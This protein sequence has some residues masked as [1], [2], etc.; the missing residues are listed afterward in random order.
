LIIV[1][2]PFP[3]L[4]LS[5][6]TPSGISTETIK[7]DRLSLKLLREAIGN[8]EIRTLS[9]SKIDEFKTVCLTRGARPQTVN[10]Y[11]RHIKGALS[12]A[13]DEKLIEKRPKIKMV[14][15]DE[16]DLAERI[17]APRTI[18][19][20]L[21]AAKVD[22]RDFGRYLTVLLWTGAR[23][24]EI[25][26]LTW[27]DVDIA[28]GSALLTHTKGK[29]N[30]RVPLLPAAISALKPMQKDIGSV[31]PTWHPDTVS[32]WF[33]QSPWNVALTPGSMTS[34]TAP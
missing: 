18:R 34:G 19:A 10:G 31:F 29:R 12:Y 2:L 9:S 16:Q 33:M 28:H 1:V 26:H 17:I 7:K 5:T 15:V 32:K 6:N 27:Q 3:N 22:D 11:L 8:I 4:P 30:R 24:R 20:I 25:L 13:V 23:R 21:D 14:P